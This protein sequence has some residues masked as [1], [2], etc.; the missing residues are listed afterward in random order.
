LILVEIW[1]HDLIYL[2]NNHFNR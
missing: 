1:L 2:V